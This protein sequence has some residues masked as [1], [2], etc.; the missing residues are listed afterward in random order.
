MFAGEGTAVADDEIG[1]FLHE[2]AEFG[3]SVFR[4][5][6][7]VESRVHAAVAEVAVE[8]AFVGERGHHLAQIAEIAAEFVG[9][10]GGVFPSF[11]VQRFAGH[12]RGRA[13]TGLANIP[14]ALG[15]RARV[16]AHVRR[17]GT[18]VESVH[19]AASLRLGFPR[20]LGRQTRP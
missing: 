17:L 4:L 3:D 1:S 9:S 2:L 8:R 7:E 15:L 13:E 19:Q 5:Q 10:D 18:A 12:V 11:P 16:E 6:I 20:G 14:N